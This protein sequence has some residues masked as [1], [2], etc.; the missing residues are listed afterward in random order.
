MDCS[1][2]YELIIQSFRYKMHSEPLTDPG[3]VSQTRQ[4]NVDQQIARATFLDERRQ[5]IQS[6]FY[7]AS[8]VV[9]SLLASFKEYTK[10]RQQDS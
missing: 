5:Y 3:D 9:V 6:S 1:N 4:S 10:W 7:Y 8:D 2:I